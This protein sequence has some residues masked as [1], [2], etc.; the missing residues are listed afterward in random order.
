MQGTK[1]QFNHKR[2]EHVLS[3][4]EKELKNEVQREIEQ[5][6]PFLTNI[7]Q[8]KVRAKVAKERGEAADF[9]MRILQDYD[10][11]SGAEAA[12]HLRATLKHLQDKGTT[13]PNK[14][15]GGKKKNGLGAGGGSRSVGRRQKQNGPSKRGQKQVSGSRV[16]GESSNAAVSKQQQIHYLKAKAVSPM[17]ELT[18]M[19]LMNEAI[20]REQEEENQVIENVLYGS[21]PVVISLSVLFL[22]L[23]IADYVSSL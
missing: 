12:C 4:L 15:K 16:G 10:L 20:R 6:K 8:A 7:E 9:L 14:I 23:C 19:D 13:S 21:L 11:V 5:L 2:Y 3:L 22:L 17:A 1:A 18:A